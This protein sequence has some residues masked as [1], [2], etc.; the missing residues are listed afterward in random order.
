MKY[1]ILSCAVL[2]PAASFGQDIES[3]QK[4][5]DL[6][7]L[8][9]SEAYCGFAFDQAA[10]SAWID[11]NTDPSDMGFAGMLNTMT[12]GAAYEFEGH[13]ESQKSAHCHS[14]ERSAKHFGFITG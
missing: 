5:S 3:M 13:T 2:F 4:A 7:N 6:G 14:V 11:A 1:L 9:A 8:L 12:A 10:I